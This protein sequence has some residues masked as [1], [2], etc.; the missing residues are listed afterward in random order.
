VDKFA[1]VPFH[2]EDH[3]LPILEGVCG[4]ARG[5]LVSVLHGGDRLIVLASVDREETDPTKQPL[6]VHDLSRSLSPAIMAQLE[7]KYMRDVERDRR[8]LHDP[9]TVV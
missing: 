6:C 8:L 5:T 3:Q 1:S 9:R 7:E 4:W 2:L